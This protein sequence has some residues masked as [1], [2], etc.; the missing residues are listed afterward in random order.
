MENSSLSEVFDDKTALD[1]LVTL[2]KNIQANAQE[3]M[4]AVIHENA[5]LLTRLNEATASQSLAVIKQD[6]LDK[7]HKNEIITSKLYIM[8]RH[9]LEQDKN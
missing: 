7:L 2:Y 9:E 3:K 8:L 5:E 4:Q 6:T 1:K